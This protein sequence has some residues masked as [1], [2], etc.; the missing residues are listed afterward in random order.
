MI[1]NKPP[2]TAYKIF[3]LTNPN[4]SVLIIAE[5]LHAIL[6]KFPDFGRY[7]F[8]NLDKISIA[9]EKP[10]YDVYSVSRHSP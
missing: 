4:T 10:N 2:P 6:I 1:W 9:G 8:S 3:T 5:D 7:H